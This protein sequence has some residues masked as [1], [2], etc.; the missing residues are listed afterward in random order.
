MNPKKTY[1]IIVLL[2]LTACGV[3]TPGGYVLG[4]T[5]YLEEVNR[6]RGEHIPERERTELANLVN[7]GGR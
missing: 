5:G 6:G 7:K 1:L 4:T 2:S 3:S